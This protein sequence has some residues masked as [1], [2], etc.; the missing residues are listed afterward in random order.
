MLL[1]GK[2]VAQRHCEALLTVY[3]DDGEDK[4]IKLS[5]SGSKSTRVNDLDIDW[6]F[7][8]FKVLNDRV[9]VAIRHPGLVRQQTK[10]WRQAAEV[11][12]G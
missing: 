2:I 10:L 1:I 11:G 9:L 12:G 8:P 4:E 6:G 5:T 3:A 7:A